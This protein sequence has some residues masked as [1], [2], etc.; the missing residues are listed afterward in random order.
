MKIL[1]LEDD[2]FICESIKS[3]FEL[4]G[5]RV[6]FFNDGEELLDNAILTNY[7]IFLFDINT[8][9]KNG[10]ETLKAIRDDG[11]STPAI[12]LT[13]QSDIEHVKQGYALGC[14]DYVRK[15]FI[16]D[17]LEL[18]INQILHK[19]LCCDDI[20]I[21]ESYSFNLCLM[22]LKFEG[23]SIDL[24]QQEK[25]LLYILVKNMGHIVSPSI[26]K[27]YVWDEKDVCDN[28]LRTQIKKIRAKLK[29]NFIINIRNSG[30]K[31]EKYA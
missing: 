5:N 6:D 26:I 12:Y 18:R 17:E 31:I 25:D 20:K 24:K 16:L 30:Y 7:D 2:N 9:K 21:T 28:T 15:P 23:E 3:Y 29:D 10:F 19:D 22:Q 13:A 14:S 4:D 1:L 27:D 11:I 8:P